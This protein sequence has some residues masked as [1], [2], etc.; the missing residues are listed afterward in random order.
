VVL[1]LLL[2]LLK[3]LAESPAFWDSARIISNAFNK[4]CQ[5]L[6]RQTAPGSQKKIRA[7]RVIRGSSFAFS[8]SF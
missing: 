8:S 1:L 4:T 7:I 2:L 6:N 5:P 3:Y